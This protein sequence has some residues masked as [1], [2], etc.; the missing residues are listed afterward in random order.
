MMH[1]DDGNQCKVSSSDTVRPENL[2]KKG[3]YDETL[4]FWVIVVQKGNK[5]IYLILFFD[6]QKLSENRQRTAKPLQD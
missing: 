5:G 6:Q 2:S 4:K 1:F 3:S